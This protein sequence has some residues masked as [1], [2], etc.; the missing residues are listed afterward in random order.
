M[1]VRT[2][3]LALNAHRNLGMT[4]LQQARASQRLS[5]GFRIN[6][7]ADDAA[8]LGISEKMRAQIRGLDQAARNAQDGISLI[9]TA[10]GALGT[11]NDMVTRIRDLVVQA[12]NDTNAHLMENEA[13]WSQSDRTRIQDEINQLMAE[14]DGTVLRT[15]FNTRTLL[16]GSLSGTPAGGTTDTPAGPPPVAW[17]AG[18]ALDFARLLRLGGAGATA[19]VFPF[20]APDSASTDPSRDGNTFELR[21]DQVHGALNTVL[22]DQFVRNTL[23]D[24][25]TFASYLSARINGA[26]ADLVGWDGVSDA[27]MNAAVNKWLSSQGVYNATTGSELQ[28]F[29]HLFDPA[30]NSNAQVLAA[31]EVVI[32][33]LANID[34]TQVISRIPDPEPGPDLT[35]LFGFNNNSITLLNPGQLTDIV[36]ATNAARGALAQF[37][38]DAMGT[39]INDAGYPVSAITQD[40]VTWLNANG[41]GG[42]NGTA[43]VPFLSLWNVPSGGDLGFPGLVNTANFAT[44]QA[45]LEAEQFNPGWNE[46][47]IDSAGLIVPGDNAMALGGNLNIGD[48]GPGVHQVN[49]GITGAHAAR[50]M[51]ANGHALTKSTG[52]LTET[53]TFAHSTSAGG[54]REVVFELFVSTALSGESAAAFLANPNANSAAADDLVLIWRVVPTAS[55]PGNGESVTA[56]AGL[57]AEGM[58]FRDEMI[59]F[60]NEAIRPFLPGSG[61]GEAPPATDDHGGLW[62]QIGANANQGVTLNIESVNVAALS[63]VGERGNVDDEF[64]FAKLRSDDTTFASRGQGVMRSRGEDI[65]NFITAIDFALS[66]ATS[67]RSNLGAMQNRL[68]FTIENLNVSSENLSA[69]ESRIRDADM[70]K[71]M[72]R[73]TQANILQ[74]AAISMLAQANQAPN[75]LLSL[76]R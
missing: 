10:E 22:G 40:F 57:S 25:A 12:A 19:N 45:F 70:A 1:V 8:G 55:I 44:L 60:I 67:Q 49:G 50:W 5:S 4:G 3:V 46:T 38:S 54:T 62:F 59:H 64:T 71:E 23:V 34:V 26:L 43:G 30:N 31:R 6:S 24:D 13:T 18:D 20:Y 27:S 35:P 41:T 37:M 2:N 29:R 39:Q 73:F 21:A 36:A 33:A 42:I 11:I 9:Q 14:I 74:Q 47:T 16:D 68:E 48:L 76:L 15:E 65:S 53:V 75:M 72:M 28:S 7:A 61:D 58:A 17:N 52:V 56:A 66:H 69:A 63:A 32:G 51:M